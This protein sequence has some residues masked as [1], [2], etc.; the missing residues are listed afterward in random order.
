MLVFQEVSIYENHIES[1]LATKNGLVQGV[2][3]LHAT[4]QDQADG[5]RKIP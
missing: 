5:E 3:R 1:G 2:F 4:L